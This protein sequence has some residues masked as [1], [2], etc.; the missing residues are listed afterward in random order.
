MERY[1]TQYMNN[2]FDILY[3]GEEEFNERTGI[4]TYRRPST[5]I[6][7]DL[8]DEFPI[9][10]SKK[11]YWKTTVNEML[12]MFQKCSNN[13]KDLGNH[14]WDSWADENGS[15][16][17]TYGY[18]V[19]QDVRTK[20]M[21]YPTQ[22]HY[23]LDRLA[24]NPSDRQCVIDMWNPEDLKDMNLP[25]CVYSSI[26]SVIKGRLNC[27][28]VQRSSDYPV[29]VP[30]DTTEYAILTHMFARHLRLRVGRL[31]HVM[32]DSHIYKNQTEGVVEHFRQYRNFD[33][34]NAKKP[35][36]VFKEDAPTNF[37]ELK[38]EDVEVVD[39]EPAPFI[40]FEVAV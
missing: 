27:M 24:K 3:C 17:K 2:L 4:S 14:I 39:Y 36:L 5:Q 9:L 1:E 35:K 20:E 22:V 29:G 34:D 15:I 12:W 31:T 21:N 19:G 30:F 37:W 18:Q 38:A 40:K 28:I 23:V 33:F 16:G 25:P 11:I 32:G 13:V 8:E 26:W 7:V 10:L 6:V